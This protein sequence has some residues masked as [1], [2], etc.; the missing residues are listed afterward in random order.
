MQGDRTSFGF[1]RNLGFLFQ[2]T[3]DTVDSIQEILFA[4]EL[5]AVAGCNQ[6]RFIADIGNIRTGESRSLACQQIYVHCII[7]LNRAQMYAE[8]FLTFVQVGQVY[9]YLT[10]E[11]SGTKQRLVQH[12]YAVG[13]S[14]NDNTTVGT[15]AIHLCQQL[16]QCVLAFIISTHCRVLATCTSHSINLINKDDTGSLFLC[17][18]EQVADT[19]C[20]YT[21][22]HFHEVRTRQREER[23][24]RF[25]GNSLGKQRLTGSRRAYQQCTLRYFTTQVC[26]F[27]RFFQ[28]LH[29]FFHFLLGFRQ[30][31]HILECDFDRTTFFKKLCF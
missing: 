19:G 2:T 12:V 1:R 4:Y 18:L 31:C 28:E 23:H 3:D 5:L 9:M 14:Q 21:H 26:I 7:Y 29:N 30:T 13:S 22:E 8:Y 10:V 16:V 15:E 27:L 24:I 25:T 20:T 6:C 17:L 11:T